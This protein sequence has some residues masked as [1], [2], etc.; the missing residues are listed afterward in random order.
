MNVGD[1]VRHHANIHDNWYGLGTV[2]KI[3][4]SSL[5]GSFYQYSVYWPGCVDGPRTS[6]YY[7]D[8]DKVLE[9]VNMWWKT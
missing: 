9:A 1:K 7:D 2:V 6:I 3:D 4:Q 8:V 5:P